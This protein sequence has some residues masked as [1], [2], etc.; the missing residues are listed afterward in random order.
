MSKLVAILGLAALVVVAGDLSFAGDPPGLAKQAPPSKA[1][2]GGCASPQDVFEKIKTSNDAAGYMSFA[3]FYPYLSKES[4]DAAEIFLFQRA[5]W[6]AGTSGKA[7]EAK[8]LAIWKKHGI[9]GNWEDA[10]KAKVVS[11]PDAILTAV[12]AQL[13]PAPDR[14]ALV[15]DLEVFSNEHEDSQRSMREKAMPKHLKLKDLQVQGDRATA[16]IGV[17][18]HTFLREGG[19]WYWSLK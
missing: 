17:K 11:G 18:R 19:R 4:R 14:V 3:L 9:K 8:F 15:R 16:L 1:A 7:V 2:G 13:A 12:R 10:K 5:S 6:A